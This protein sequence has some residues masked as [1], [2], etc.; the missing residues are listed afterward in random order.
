LTGGLYA[1]DAASGSWPAVA[2]GGLLA[3]AVFAVGIAGWRFGRISL[4]AAEAAPLF[5]PGWRS[6]PDR[7]GAI[8]DALEIPAEFR[9][10]GWERIDQ[11]LT[12]GSIWLWIVLLAVLAIVVT[13]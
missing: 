5:A 9:V 12:R 3:V 1:T 2:L 7:L 4:P 6:L 11:A 10:T 13:R 8:A